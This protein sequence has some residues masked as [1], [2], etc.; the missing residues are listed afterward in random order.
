M[1]DTVK[2]RS[3]R[4]L[5][6]PVLNGIGHQNGAQ[7]TREIPSAVTKRPGETLQSEEPKRARTQEPKQRFEEMFDKSKPFILARFDEAAMGTVERFKGPIN[8]VIAANKKLLEVYP[9]IQN[10][11]RAVDKAVERVQEATQALVASL[12]AHWIATPPV[13]QPHTNR[14]TSESRAAGPS[15]GHCSSHGHTQPNEAPVGYQNSSEADSDLRARAE[16]A[17]L[18]IQNDDGDRGSFPL[19]EPNSKPISVPYDNI[20]DV[21]LTPA[22]K[23]A[24]TRARNKILRAKEDMPKQ[25]PPTQ[26]IE[27]DQLTVKNV[28]SD[29]V[30]EA[31]VQALSNGRPT[32]P[33]QQQTHSAVTDHNADRSAQNPPGERRESAAVSDRSGGGNTDTS[34]KWKEHYQPRTQPKSVG[35]G[36]ASAPTKTPVCVEPNSVTAN[37]PET[38]SGPEQLPSHTPR[39]RGVARHRRT[40]EE[41]D[42]DYQLSDEEPKQAQKTTKPKNNSQS[43]TGAPTVR[44]Q[45]QIQPALKKH[46]NPERAPKPMPEYSRRLNVGIKELLSTVPQDERTTSRS[47][48]NSRR[49][50]KGASSDKSPPRAQAQSKGV[51]SKTVESEQ[52]KEQV[53]QENQEKTSRKLKLVLKN[54]GSKSSPTEAGASSPTVELSAAPAVSLKLMDDAFE[55]AIKNS[56]SEIPAI[57]PEQWLQ[58]QSQA[59]SSSSGSKVDSKGKQA[60]YANEAARSCASYPAVPECPV[61]RSSSSEATSIASVA[62]QAHTANKA[63]STAQRFGAPASLPGARVSP[64]PINIVHDKLPATERISPEQFAQ[65]RSPPN[66][67]TSSI[68]LGDGSDD[69]DEPS[70]SPPSLPR[71]SQAAAPESAPDATVSVIR[72]Q[73]SRTTE[74]IAAEG[75]TQM[76]ATTKWPEHVSFS[77]FVG[78]MGEHAM[79]QEPGTSAWLAAVEDTQDAVFTKDGRDLE[80]EFG[81]GGVTGSGA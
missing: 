62:Q 20:P 40:I 61:E 19:H 65:P 64:T 53:R 27:K 9:Y 12:P 75:L 21:K 76:A 59:S 49:D 35:S 5:V 43:S 30:A 32:A 69:D 31:S 8:A 1:H 60:I 72:P 51:Q 25:L 37:V 47:P 18:P 46:N 66:I 28:A 45:G 22:Q 58:A 4:K 3:G 23:A 14:V 38:A 71:R 48:R 44:S 29:S 70:D 67:I 52:G 56:Q 11:L 73:P 78:Q 13:S 55:E 7:E 17:R 10:E 39:R 2:G 6:L 33:T 41:S 74:K 26:S 36:P 80:E 79:Q 81:R 77:Q 68:D 63:A 42:S 34:S 54:S 16:E 57:D 50:S 24:R 15:D